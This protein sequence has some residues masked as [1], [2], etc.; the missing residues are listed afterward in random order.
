MWH[1]VPN[2]HAMFTW[3]DLGLHDQ[4]NIFITNTTFYE[5]VE[6]KIPSYSYIE[7]VIESSCLKQYF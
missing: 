4:Y 5:C 6:R 7:I 2:N 1:L 3:P